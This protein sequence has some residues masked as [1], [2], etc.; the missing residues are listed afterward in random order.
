MNKSRLQLLEET[1][2]VYGYVWQSKY[3]SK[4]AYL[5][6]HLLVL[7]MMPYSMVEA[8]TLACQL[9]QNV[10]NFAFQMYIWM[11]CKSSL[12]EFCVGWRGGSRGGFAQW[13]QMETIPYSIP[14]CELLQV[15]EGDIVHFPAPKNFMRRDIV[16]E[17]D[18]PFFAT[19][20]A[21]LTLVKGGASI[22]LTPKWWKC[23]GECSNYI[24]KYQKLSKNE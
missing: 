19:S 14:W 16:L 23:D 21:P 18:T 9:W 10:S 7:S 20:D 11:F 1:A 3:W 5:C 13:F 15:L 22:V 24:T 12:G 8:S 2:R 6:L 4:M 17:K